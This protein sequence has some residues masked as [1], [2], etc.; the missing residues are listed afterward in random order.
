MEEHYMFLSSRD[1]LEFFPENKAHSFEVK[2]PGTLKLEGR[3][4]CALTELVYVPQFTGERPKQIY[5]C[6]DLV[7]DSYVADSMLPIM[8]KVAVP[9]AIGTRTSLT[10]PQNYY[11]PLARNEIQY[12]NVYV[13]DHNLNAPEFSQ[14]PLSCTLHLVREWNRSGTD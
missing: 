7:Q 8:R 9:T 10:F 12:I 14:E 2:L 6:C 4:K 5:V 11:F 3:W 1:S 13:K